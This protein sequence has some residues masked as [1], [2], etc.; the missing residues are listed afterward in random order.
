MTE[1][2]L[3]SSNLNDLGEDY[4][5]VTELAFVGDALMMVNLDEVYAT[6]CDQMDPSILANEE[7]LK[8]LEPVDLLM[9][10]LN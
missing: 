4:G 7:K 2:V 5:S 1:F 10:E 8:P 6:T 9:T 3:D